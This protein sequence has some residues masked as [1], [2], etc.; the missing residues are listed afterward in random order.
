MRCAATAWISAGVASPG[1]YSG[2]R[3]GGVLGYGGGRLDG[4]HRTGANWFC[5]YGGRWLMKSGPRLLVFRRTW[6]RLDV[7]R[8]WTAGADRRR[9]PGAGRRRISGRRRQAVVAV[10]WW[11]D[12]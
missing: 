1:V 8:R 5:A 4:R 2:S 7:V 11:R 12:V 6:R 10:G 9:S 3:G